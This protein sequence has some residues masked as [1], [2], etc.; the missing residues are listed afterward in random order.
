MLYTI[1]K[2]F[3]TNKED[4]EKHAA[5]EQRQ[6]A[7]DVE[8]TLRLLEQRLHE[9]E[10]TAASIQDTLQTACRFYQGDWAGFFEVDRTLALWTPCVWHDN[11]GGQTGAQWNS[12]QSTEPLSTWMDAMRHDRA[13]CIASDADRKACTAAER[14]LYQRFDVRTLLAVPI[15]TQP[16]GFVVVRNP[17]RYAD[18]SDMLQMLA[19][20]VRAFLREQAWAKRVQAAVPPEGIEKTTDVSVRLFGQLEICAYHGRLRQSDLQ[21]P[22]L[23]RMLAYLLLHEHRTIPAE[24]LARAVWRE[25]ADERSQPDTALRTLLF[26]W[27][28]AFRTISDHEL[29]EVVPNGY[30]LCTDMHVTTDVRQLEQCWNA[31]QQE[32]RAAD[33]IQVLKQAVQLYRGDL[34]CAD[35]QTPWLTDAAAQCRTRY[36]GLAHELLKTLADEKAY[37]PLQQYAAQAL[38]VDQSDGTAHYWLIYAMTKMG[39]HELA[40]AQLQLAQEALT[41]ADYE[42]LIRKVKRIEPLAAADEALVPPTAKTVGDLLEE[43]MSIY[44][45]NI[46]TMSTYENRKSLIANY[47][48]PLIGDMR[49]E[50]VSPR[51]MDKFYRDLLSVRSVSVN[52]VKPRSEFLTPHTVK[53]IHK[54]LRNAFNQAVKWE[55]MTRNPVEHATL[56]KEEHKTREIWTVDILQKALEVCDDDILRLAINLAFSCSLRMGELLG[57]TWDCVDISPASIA[58]GQA[59]IFVEKELQ[60]VNCEAMADLNGKDI[61]LQFPPTFANSTH[62]AL[63]LK[64]PKTKTSVRKVF[65][66]KTVAKMLVKRREEIEHLKELYGD[67]FVDFNLVFCSSSGKPIEGQVINRAFNRL[68][69]ENGL[70]KVV[71]HS[72]RH[73]S[74]TYKLK[75]NGGDVKS[76]QGDSGHA[77]VKMVTDIY[78]HIIDDDRRRNAER[79]EAA[80]YSGKADAP[81]A[82][83]ETTVSEEEKELILKL[84]RNPEMA[85]FLKSL[86]KSL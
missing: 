28:R 32:T 11:N 65:L 34:V 1:Q 33:K 69:E 15:T 31:A 3:G 20:V 60:R 49:L 86:A 5:T 74:I 14:A 53:E 13:V 70:P 51:V 52:N 10:D 26:C 71:F 42:E 36:R 46:W 50:D 79:M 55:L 81:A 43:Y 17:Q 66:P 37:R 16:T 4:A 44:G 22:E 56:P 75:L 77:Q 59:S 83:Q 61:V 76:V 57:L 38:T 6:Y 80:F 64:A 2:L 40:K 47:I 82:P 58:A 12:I 68:I 29:I 27:R 9:T 48:R 23:C 67:E 78:S 73:S 19:S 62:T 85:A 8:Q 45:A 63:V 54:V 84:L 72:L 7:Q 41:D 25:Q 30:R 18:R 35:A 21:S 39:I 24:E